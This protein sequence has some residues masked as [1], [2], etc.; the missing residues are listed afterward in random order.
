M[1]FIENKKLLKSYQTFFDTLISPCSYMNQFITSHFHHQHARL[2]LNIT[3]TNSFHKY[4][5]SVDNDWNGLSA[6]SVHANIYIYV[7]MHDII[8]IV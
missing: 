6:R 4:L 3:I 2:K 1:V 8:C 5:R 7:Y